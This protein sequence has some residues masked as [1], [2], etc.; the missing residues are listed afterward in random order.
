MAFEKQALPNGRPVLKASAPRLAG[1]G[2]VQP[3]FSGSSVSS[4]PST[5]RKDTSSK[6]P[7]TPT[8]QKEDV[9][10]PVKAFLSSNITP[11]S[12]SRRARVDSAS[13]TPNGTPDGTPKATRPV[14]MVERWDDGVSGRAVGSSALGISGLDEGRAMRTQSVVSEGA[15]VSRPY[16]RPSS[17]QS[18]ARRGNVASPEDLPKFFHADEAKPRLSSKSESQRP[19]LQTVFSGYTQNGGEDREDS[20]SSLSTSPSLSLERPKFFRA[21]S[22]AEAVKPAVGPPSRSTTRQPPFQ[23]PSN[24]QLTSGQRAASPLKDEVKTRD[25]SCQEASNVTPLSRRSSLNISAPDNGSLSRKPSVGKP[26]PRRHTRLVSNSAPITA[27]DIRP[28]SVVPPS[29]T[30]T[31]KTTDLSR[32]SS[33]NLSSPRKASHARSSSISGIN[34]P[35]SRRSSIALSDTITRTSPNAARPS[36][37]IQPLQSPPQNSNISMSLQPQPTPPLSPT[38]FSQPPVQSKL[39]H[40]NELAAQA[41]RERKVLDLEISNSSLLAINRTLEREM[42]KQKEEL[43][44]LRRSSRRTADGRVISMATNRTVSSRMSGLSETTGNDGDLDIGFNGNISSEAEEETLSDAYND[45]ET[46][47]LSSSTSSPPPISSSFAKDTK[48]LNLD[49]S[50]HRALLVDSQKL[51]QTIK[52]CLDT[53]ESLISDGKKALDYRIDVSEIENLPLH[54][55]KQ[56]DASWN[57]TKTTMISVNE[58]E[59]ADADAD[60]EWDIDGIGTAITSPLASPSPATSHPTFPPDA[61]LSPRSSAALKT[62][63]DA[64][65]QDVKTPDGL[66]AAAPLGLGNYLQSLGWS[67]GSVG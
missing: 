66:R 7:V 30:S 39:D 24:A 43:R 36:P 58:Q 8:S 65:K 15:R 35:H 14:S 41:R 28:P 1:R 40:L 50:R 62:G 60:P 4:T 64:I 47:S 22:S 19:P 27:Q 61:E 55:G 23:S 33:L 29:T 59:E 13:T 34:P 48:R 37:S 67:P 18:G 44:K 49:L 2:T 10:T 56:A 25:T 21:N 11:R 3:K 5:L 51:N 42:R 6:S 45:D 26:S 31:T 32:R 16:S 54:L 57:G 46:R 20:M 9:S 17:A 52:R 12:G 53:T 63:W 38:R